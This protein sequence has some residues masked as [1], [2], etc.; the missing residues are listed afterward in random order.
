MFNEHTDIGLHTKTKHTQGLYW[1]WG[2]H[3]SSSHKVS[4]SMGKEGGGGVGVVH[5]HVGIT[6]EGSNV[7]L[8]FTVDNKK[9]HWMH[10]ITCCN[11]VITLANNY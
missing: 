9:Q 5:H 4:P 2:K 1:L 11:H 3:W 7:S 8:E 6:W 10:D